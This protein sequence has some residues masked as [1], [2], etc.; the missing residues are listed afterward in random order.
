MGWNRE[1]W[2]KLRQS[3][4][5]LGLGASLGLSAWAQDCREFNG[6]L[7]KSLHFV[8]DSKNGVAQFIDGAFI[9]RNRNIGSAYTTPCT[10][11]QQSQLK[12]RTQW[13]F[14]KLRTSNYFGSKDGKKAA[15]GDH[16][17]VLLRASFQYETGP[18]GEQK[19]ARYRFRGPIFHRELGVL[20]EYSSIIDKPDNQFPGLAL[21]SN[22]CED[23][24]TIGAGGQTNWAAA[25]CSLNSYPKGPVNPMVLR[26]DV[27]YLVLAHATAFGITYWVAEGSVEGP[28]VYRFFSEASDNG[29]SPP[30]QLKVPPHDLSAYGGFGVA[31][32]CNAPAGYTPGSCEVSDFSVSLTEIT[33]GWF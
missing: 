28:L 31:V 26:D 8:G 20:G 14:F 29:L 18:Y 27:T 33:F 10:H 15:V 23:V 30:L 1:A 5:C 24:P 11:Q 21:V 6:G 3:L 2:R 17:P 32:L 7:P 19:I 9:V 12:N 4:W 25:P 22:V 13:V 16:I